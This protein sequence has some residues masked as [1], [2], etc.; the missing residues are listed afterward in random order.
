[1]LVLA[2]GWLVYQM[3]NSPFMLGAV[4]GAYSIP[5]VILALPGGALAD[6]LN[7]R[8]LMI[9]SEVIVG[10]MSLGIA[11]LI[12]FGSIA[13]WHLMLASFVSGIAFAI[14][15][16]AKMAIIPDLVGRDIMMNA[17]A[18]GSAGFNAMRILAPSIGG[19]LLVF[20]GMAPVYFIGTALS[21]LGI[22][23]LLLLPAREGVRERS[24]ASFGEDV[25]SGVKYVY[26]NKT[27]FTIFIL[28]LL[29]TLIA[30]P[31][32]YF[33][34]VFARDI[35]KAGE[36]GLGW[37]MAAT[38]LG[39]VISNLFIASMGDFRRKSYLLLGFMGFLGILLT[40]FSYSTI[41]VL[42]LIFLVMMG[43]CA[44]GFNTM[45]NT[46][47]QTHSSTEMRGRALSIMTL[48]FG[49]APLG[50]MPLGAV[51]EVTGVPLALTMGGLLVSSITL[52]VFILHRNFRQL[53]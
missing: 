25:R 35:L 47:L 28:I 27:V 18:L 16:P 48:A 40:I 3:T 13:V 19:F 15:Q 31:F 50:A 17:I 7:R 1:M 21:I 5:V 10:F 8:N 24:G 44:T 6:R 43:M 49:I 14:G 26:Q 29:T 37:M 42:S 32:Q 30:Q 9:A 4:S 53:S 45:S 22:V 46:L 41:L 38:G 39:A 34:P 52:G 23:F 11:A 36:V 51:A 33:L 2:R 12:A 20:L